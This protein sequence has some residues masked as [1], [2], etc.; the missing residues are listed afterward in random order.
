VRKNEENE[1]RESPL[2]HLVTHEAECAQLWLKVPEHDV[3]VAARRRELLE[4][5]AEGDRGDIICVTSEGP[6]Q[7]WILF[8]HFLFSCAQGAM[9]RREGAKGDLQREYRTAE[10]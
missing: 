7:R 2:S 3:V 4:V 8:A 9:S 5:R 1:E 10:V 6:L